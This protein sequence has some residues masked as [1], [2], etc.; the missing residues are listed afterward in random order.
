MNQKQSLTTSL[1]VLISGTFLLTQFVFPELESQFALIHGGT[2]V[3][4]YFPGVY[5]GQWWRLFTVALTHAGWLHLVFN[6]LALYSIGTPV[7]EFVGKFRFGI[8]FLG[9]LLAASA[10]SLYF[11]P[12]NIYAV[13]AS[14]AVYGLFGALFF[15]PVGGV[16]QNPSALRCDR[17]IAFNASLGLPGPIGQWRGRYRDRQLA[18]FTGRHA[19]SLLV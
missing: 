11:G 9:S 15:A 5:T 6:M 13:G 7:E 1:I 18:F 16:D 3:S 14:G 4:G 10:T 19:P 8:I 17:N 12:E 2:Y